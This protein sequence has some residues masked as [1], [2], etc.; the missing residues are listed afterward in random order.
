ML[1]VQ[2]CCVVYKYVILL[3]LCATYADTICTAAL[4]C[5]QV[6]NDTD[7]KYSISM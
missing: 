7:T 6:C 3:I 2:L 4:C 5:I 1:P